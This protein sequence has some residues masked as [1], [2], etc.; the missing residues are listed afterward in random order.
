MAAPS[1]SIT[2][3]H[4]FGRRGQGFQ[5]AV[6][7]SPIVS[8]FFRGSGLC[9]TCRHANSKTPPCRRLD[10]Y[11]ILSGMQLLR[12]DSLQQF[13]TPAPDSEVSGWCGSGRRRRKL[14]RRRERYSLPSNSVADLHIRSTPTRPH[15]L[16]KCSS[17]P[18][19][20]RNTHTRQVC[21]FGRISRMA[22][23][24]MIGQ[25]YSYPRAASTSES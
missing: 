19:L 10:G 12:Q 7:S 18:S 3:R 15:V 4:N 14:G 5:A 8:R 13:T 17:R 16:T 6:A 9:A 24:L 2:R 20:T 1:I 21:N 11:C 23:R 22:V 25:C